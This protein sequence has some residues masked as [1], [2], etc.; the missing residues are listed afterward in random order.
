M[1]SD[2]RVSIDFPD[3]PKHKRLIRKLGLGATNMLLRLWASVAVRRPQGVLTGW[4]EVDIAEAAGWPEDRDAHELIGALLGD[5]GKPAFLEQVDGVYRLHDWQEHQGWACGAAARSAKA[6]T[7]AEAKWAKRNAHPPRREALKPHEYKNVRSRR[8]AEARLKGT[9][10]EAEWAALLQVF[11][12]QC[13]KC[14]ST[15]DIV[16]DHITP[17]YQGGSDGIENIQPL[18]GKCN[19]SKGPDRTDYRARLHPKI[20]WST[21]A[22][23]EQCIVYLEH[24]KMPAPSPSPSPFPSSPNPT[25]NTVRRSSKATRKSE[26][27]PTTNLVSPDGELVGATLHSFQCIKDNLR[28][29]AADTVDARNECRRHTPDMIRAAVKEACVQNKPTWKYT[30][31]ILRRWESEGKR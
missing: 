24:N 15:Q 26:V 11:D 3:H 5:N 13:L 8:L 14:G 18:C 19:S 27:V 30:A 12:H 2:I 16:K 17:L 9:H 21:N 1:I 29:S 31:A 23:V 28:L 22:C 7:A 6:K 25:R 4:D 20:D 10:T